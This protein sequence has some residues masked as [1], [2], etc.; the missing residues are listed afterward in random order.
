MIP[1]CWQYYG[2]NLNHPCP[3]WLLQLPTSLPVSPIYPLSS[4]STYKANLSLKN[5]NWVMKLPCLKIFRV[6]SHFLR[7]KFKHFIFLLCPWRSTW[8]GC[9]PN[10]LLTP[11]SAL[12]TIHTSLLSDPVKYRALSYLPAFALCVPLPE[13]LFLPLFIYLA[14]IN[15]L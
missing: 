13:I 14:N 7:M 11:L 3:S 9:L 15:S 12:C 1:K 10:P 8:F 2:E 5:E 4:F 6:I